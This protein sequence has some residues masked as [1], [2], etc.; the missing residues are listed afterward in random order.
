MYDE[1]QLVLGDKSHLEYD[2]VE[3]LTYLNQVINETLR[4]FPPAI[5]VAKM[6]IADTEIERYPFPTDVSFFNQFL[7]F[8]KSYLEIDIVGLHYNPKVWKNPENFDPDRW[9]PERIKEIPLLR[10]SWIPFSAGSRNC[11][12]KLFAQT[13]APLLCSMI[14]QEYS[15]DLIDKNDKV[16]MDATFILKAENL[17]LKLT[18]RN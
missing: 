4:M 2:D 1:I 10:F 12:G 15:V 17:N 3:K 11:V 6:A 14:L 16:S 13:E 9:S 18:K 8:L 7:I 5:S